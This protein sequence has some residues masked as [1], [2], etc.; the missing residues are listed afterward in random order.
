MGK[1]A[2]IGVALALLVAFAV[3]GIA[4]GDTD[5]ADVPQPIQ[6]PAA[7][8]KTPFAILG[9]GIQLMGYLLGDFDPIL[10]NAGFDL[11]LAL[12]DFETPALRAGAWVAGPVAWMTD[13]MGWTIV[14][15]GDVVRESDAVLESAGVSVPIDLGAVANIFYVVAAR[16]FDEWGILI[17]LLGDLGPRLGG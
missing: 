8:S 2:S 4:A 13:M 11:P 1:L 6:H 16:M 5:W 15:G 10:E 14:I 3:P 17:P 12:G 9:S 7:Y